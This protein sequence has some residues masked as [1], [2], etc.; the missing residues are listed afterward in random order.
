MTTA[1]G[2]RINIQKKHHVYRKR[3]KNSRSGYKLMTVKKTTYKKGPFIKHVLNCKWEVSMA[4][5][6]KLDAKSF[7]WWEKMMQ[8]MAI[9]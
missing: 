1:Y 4:G 2:E 7:D 5:R 9:N 8:A 6:S 3:H